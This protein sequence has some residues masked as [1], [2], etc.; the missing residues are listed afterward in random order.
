MF[1]MFGKN[2]DRYNKIFSWV[3]GVAVIAS[4]LLAYFSLLF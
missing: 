2:R 1:G 3:V 4:M